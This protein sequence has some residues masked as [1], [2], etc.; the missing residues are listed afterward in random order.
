MLYLS[1]KYS[2]AV[3]YAATAHAEQVRKGTTIPYVSHPLAV[4]ALV[5]EHGGS[6]RARPE[7]RGEDRQDAGA[8]LEADPEVM[9]RMTK[10]ELDAA[11]D[12]TLS[13]RAV[14]RIF[15]RVFLER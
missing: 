7:A 15:A 4:S 13:T 5:I 9:D 1:D 8:N 2:E 11:Y 6:G 10:A 12:P 3:G 14:D